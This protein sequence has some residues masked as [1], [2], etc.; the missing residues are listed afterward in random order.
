[1]PLLLLRSKISTPLDILPSLRHFLA[2][3]LWWALMPH[4]RDVEKLSAFRYGRA[5][6][7]FK[8]TQNCM[9]D[10]HSQCRLTSSGS[11]LLF[12]FET[13]AV[14]KDGFF[15]RQAFSQLHVV[16]KQ[17]SIKCNMCCR[18][19]L[20]KLHYVRQ[21]IL[22]HRI[23]R[24]SLSTISVKA[25]K[26]HSARSVKKLSSFAQSR[27]SYPPFASKLS[28][29]YLLKTSRY[30]PASATEETYPG[31]LIRVEKTPSSPQWGVISQREIR[32]LR[33]R[34]SLWWP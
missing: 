11:Q 10:V 33:R 23:G 30:K 12:Q 14:Q 5:M 1:M 4:A 28:I 27:G 18:A 6:Y 2:S 8:S 31:T 29:A 21:A 24:W 22:K 25:P 7:R 9:S 17:Y 26:C 13:S 16:L 15:K 19:H 32:F 3:S 20:S 34:I